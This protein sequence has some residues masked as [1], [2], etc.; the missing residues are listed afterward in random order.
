[1]QAFINFLISCNVGEVL[2]VFFASLMGFPSILS[3]MQL[4]WVNLATDGPAAVALG[5]N[6]IDE[7]VMKERPRDVNEAIITQWLLTRYLVI[8]T[9]IGIT[10]VGIFASYYINKG[11]SL[12]YLSQWSTCSAWSDPNVCNELFG[13]DALAIPQTLAISTLVT[14]ELL[15]ALSTVSVDSSL[16]KISPLSNPYLMLGV[17]IPFC[18]HLVILYTPISTSFGLA[19]LSMEQWITVLL[20][21]FPVVLVDEVL[22][23]VGR[24][25]RS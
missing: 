18:F 16:L 22:K 10:T 5:F 17:L 1:M 8:G 3:A 7:N 9:Y 21:S 25:I 24:K 4:L 11:V 13:P 15:K 19:P 12:D 6:P 23:M 20:W 2:A 14:T